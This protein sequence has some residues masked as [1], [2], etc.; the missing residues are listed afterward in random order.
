MP[1]KALAFRDAIF[2]ILLLLRLALASQ[3]IFFHFRISLTLSFRTSYKFEGE[4]NCFVLPRNE[5]AITI[6][7]MDTK[8]DCCMKNMAQNT[9]FSSPIIV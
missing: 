5:G 9:A 4:N 3:Q 8:S 1:T 2:R 6:L 7:F